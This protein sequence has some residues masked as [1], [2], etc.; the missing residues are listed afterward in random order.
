[1]T[2]AIMLAALA[3]LLFQVGWNGVKI[4]VVLLSG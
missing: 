1:V 3:Y 4:A 2:D